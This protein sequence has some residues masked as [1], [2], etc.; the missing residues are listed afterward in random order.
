MMFS[1]VIFHLQECDIPL[2]FRRY[3][4]NKLNFA[5]LTDEGE[6]NLS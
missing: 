1:I 4:R 6:R 5:G 2:T 3:I